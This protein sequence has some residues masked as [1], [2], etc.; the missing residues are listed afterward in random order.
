[1]TLEKDRPGYIRG[2]VPE[3]GKVA[4]VTLQSFPDG[5]VTI[6]VESPTGKSDEP[7]A[8]VVD[9]ICKHLAV[10][11]GSYKRDLRKLGNSDEVD[12]CLMWMAHQDQGP[13]IRIEKKGNG[14]AHY[15]IDPE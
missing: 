12:A 13:L 9:K 5:G 10:Y 3:K 1:M 14:H 7:R 11:P 4:L 8:E 2:A 6:H 15:L